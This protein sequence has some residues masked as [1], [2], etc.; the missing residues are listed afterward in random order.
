[1]EKL[2]ESYRLDADGKGAVHL[3]HDNSRDGLEAVVSGGE[4]YVKP[5]YGHWTKRRSEGDDAARL[6]D[7]VEGVPAAYLDLFSRWLTVKELSRS[8][9]N[10]RPAVRLQLGATASPA[11]PAE[12]TDLDYKK[13][14]DTVKVRYLS[15]EWLLDAATGAPL[16]GKLEASYTFER[17]DLKGPTAVTL[18]YEQHAGAPE[19]IVAPADAV[20]PLR[21]RPLLDRDALLDGLAPPRANH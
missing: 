1:V 14:R 5:R 17:S 6:R 3:V 7:N 15:G 8:Q 21:A 18:S 20:E 13:W 19:P 16:S 12:P 9:V 11:P 10:G 2:D 4:V